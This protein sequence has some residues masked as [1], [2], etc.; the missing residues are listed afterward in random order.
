MSENLISEGTDLVE[1]LLRK[2]HEREAALE[3]E[4]HRLKAREVELLAANAAR[5]EEKRQ[6]EEDTQDLA[7]TMAEL[8]AASLSRRERQR[9]VLYW[10][11]ATF[12]EV[13]RDKRERALR[14]AEEAIEVAQAAGL[15]VGAVEKVVD[16]TYSRPPGDLAK[17][18]GGLVMTDEA[19]A[20]AHGISLPEEA[21]REWERISAIPRE[22]W[23]KRQAAKV[24]AGTAVAK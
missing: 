1:A 16:R 18:I 11:V 14:L 12:G 21:E 10:A 2:S 13:A 8:V 17:E 20:E 22:E 15:N 7:F 5:L 3:A 9:H 4:V 6:A 23:Q 24:A 19:L